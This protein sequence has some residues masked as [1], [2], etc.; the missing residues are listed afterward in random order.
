MQYFYQM[1]S[2]QFSIYFDTGGSP[3]SKSIVDV[4]P[5][6]ALRLG[7]RLP[8]WLYRWH[9][10]WL[11]GERFLLL[12]HIGRN[13]RMPRQAVIEVVAHDRDTDMYYVVSGWGAKSDWYQNVRKTPSVIVQVAGRKFRADAEF[14]PV[15]KA[16]RILETYAREHPVAFREL[17]G[18]FLGERMK[19]GSDA[20]RQLAERM[21]MVAFRPK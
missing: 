12:T 11:L 19:A 10:G 9:L 16:M 4:P 2:A 15:E 21:P 20:S 5:G 6:K 14:I 1:F 8:I 7:L 13:S 17:S 3:M 18:L